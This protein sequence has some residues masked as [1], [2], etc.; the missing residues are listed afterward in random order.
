MVDKRSI[1]GTKVVPFLSKLEKDCSKNICALIERAKLL[2]LEGFDS[3]VWS[4]SSWEI[5]SGRL[6]KQTSRNS[7]SVSLSFCFPA[8]LGGEPL[9]ANWADLIK[10]FFLIRFHRKSQAITNQRNFITAASY[11]TYFAIRVNCDIVQLVPEILERACKAISEQ[12]KNS[13]AYNLHKAVAEFAGF[14]DANKLCKVQLAYRYSK[15]KRPDNVSGTSYKR[16][17]NPETLETK[18]DKL[19][20]PEVFRII[21]QLYQNVP[22][23]HKYRFYVLLLT[24]LCCLGRRLSEIVLLPYQ[25]VSRDNDGNAYLEYF[26]R[27]SSCGDTFTPKRRLYLPTSVVEIVEPVISELDDLCHAAR[28]TAAKMQEVKGPDLSFIE[29]VSEDKKLYKEDLEE[30]GVPKSVISTTGWIR[31]QGFAFPDSCKLTVHGVKSRFPAYYTSKAAVSGFCHRDYSD[32]YIQPIH[33][34]QQNKKYYLKNLLIVRYLGLS[35]GFYTKWVATQCTHS[36]VATFLRY[37]PDL[38]RQYVNC[39]INLDFTSHHFRHTMNTLLDEGGLSDLLQTEWFGR[40]NPKDTKAYQHTSRE[41]RALLLREDIKLGKIGGQIAE[42]VMT[43]PV[44]V[45]DAYLKARVNAVHDV[46]TGICVHNFSQT[47]CERHLQCSADCK[48]YVWAKDDKGRVEDLKRQYALTKVARDTA[49]TRLQSSKPKKSVDWLNHSDK[50]L[51]TLTK[52]LHDNGVGLFNPHEY[53]EGH[54]DV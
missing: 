45:K 50:K 37:L 17:D 8:K 10:A 14:C 13:S 33:I 12:Y 35:S 51:N 31:K 1:R 21:G 4:D 47:P 15:M 39:E 32:K 42:Q 46:G 24:L 26:P 29:H 40:S 23:E 36:M 16:L 6:L 38:V 25:S 5:A 53:L 43:L 9:P 48:D 20:D 19:V 49:E 52:Q 54:T 30:L 34:D 22:K 18:S 28:V 11:V 41:K 2:N 3:V 27:K 44:Q 7:N